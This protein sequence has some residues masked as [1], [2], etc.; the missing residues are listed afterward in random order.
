MTE[1]EAYG[2]A[3]D[4]LTNGVI[5]YKQMA[6]A[7][8]R[9]APVAFVK[10]AQA[11]GAKSFQTATKAERNSLLS[12]EER[13]LAEARQRLHVVIRTAIATGVVTAIKAVRELTG[14]G[15]KD[16]KDYVDAWR[17]ETVNDIAFDPMGSWISGIREQLSQQA[18]VA[19]SEAALAALAEEDF[20]DLRPYE[21]QGTYA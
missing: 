20:G 4:L 15:L 21:E 11:Q 19:E 17:G 12:L 10:L 5:D 1:K 3:I 6:I 7:L 13:T 2:K 18:A 16:A 8:A 9:N 14:W